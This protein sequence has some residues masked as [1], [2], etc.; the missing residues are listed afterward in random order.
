LFKALE[1]FP[2]VDEGEKKED[3]IK[4]YSQTLRKVKLSGE[5]TLHLLKKEDLVGLGIPLGHAAAI[6]EAALNWGK[7]EPTK[8]KRIEDS[9]SDGSAFDKSLSK[10]NL[11]SFKPISFVTVTV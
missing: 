6:A 4:L 7:K 1:N 9:I 11:Q 10:L 5:K 8:R 3:T 2:E